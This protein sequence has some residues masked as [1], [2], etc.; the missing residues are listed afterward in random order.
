MYGPAEHMPRGV[1]NQAFADYVDRNVNVT[2]INNRK[3]PVPTVPGLFL[4][5]HHSSGEKHLDKDGVKGQDNPNISCSTGSVSTLA[6]GSVED[7]SGL[8]FSLSS[9]QSYSNIGPL[10]PYAGIKMGSSI[11]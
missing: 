8:H 3:D 4:G 7:H 10:G 2:R 5:Y 6:D 11:F 1:G 9:L